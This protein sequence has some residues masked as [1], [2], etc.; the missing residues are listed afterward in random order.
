MDEKKISDTV[1][2]LSLKNRLISYG[3]NYDNLTP[4]KIELC[5]HVIDCC[6]KD[7]KNRFLN[8]FFY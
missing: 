4:E 5:K 2:E 8:K 6:E 3:I 7:M 1:E